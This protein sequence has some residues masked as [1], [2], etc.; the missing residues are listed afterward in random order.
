MR[1]G[2]GGPQMIT[3][4]NFVGCYSKIS[5][6]RPHDSDADDFGMQ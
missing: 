2:L 1:P 3:N 5:S 4:S 6:V